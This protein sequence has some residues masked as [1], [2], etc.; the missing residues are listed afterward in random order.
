MISVIIPVYNASEWLSESVG[1]IMA[2]SYG[3]WEL[4]LVDDGSTDG[5]AVL[6]DKYTAADSRIRVLHIAN[7]GVSAARNRGLDAAKGEWLLFMDAD[8]QLHRNALEVM[9]AAAAKYGAQMVSAPLIEYSDG[10]SGWKRD[11]KPE[12]DRKFMA[13]ILA[14]AKSMTSAEGVEKQMYQREGFNP[15]V[16]GILFARE[17]WHHIRFREG[18]RYEDLDISYRL[19]LNADRMVRLREPLYAY[20]QHPH[21]FMHNFTPDRLDALKVTE[22]MEGWC[23]EHAPALLR[24]ARDRRMSACFNIL[25]LA[26]KAQADG[27]IINGVNLEEVKNEC[28]GQIVRLR[29]NSI[30][31]RHVR[32]RNRIGALVSLLGRGF[33]S[34]LYHWL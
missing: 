19:W 32:L 29:R 12:N 30:F 26:S 4:I 15:S 6:C 21:S 9:C 34:R 22:R 7:S 24:G 20:R 33:L 25:L 17:M 5:S 3:E 13:E 28:Y 14:G 1:S 2:Q 11:R 31:N 8:D 23:A 18:I 27:E 10:K 16:C